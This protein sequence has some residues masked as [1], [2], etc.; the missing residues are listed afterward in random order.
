[1]SLT[2]NKTIIVIVS[3]FSSGGVRLPQLFAGRGYDCF[4]V[5]TRREWEMK[6]VHHYFNENHF[7]KNF[8]IDDDNDLSSLLEELKKYEIKAII[9]GCESGVVLADALLQN[10]NLP[11]NNFSLSR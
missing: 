5:T 3:A 6:W 7:I 8:I 2:Y 11:K 9:P 10:F 1:M 4:H